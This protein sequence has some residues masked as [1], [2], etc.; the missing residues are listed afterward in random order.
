MRQSSPF[1]AVFRGLVN[2]F[3]FF[4]TLQVFNLRKAGA[5]CN[6]NL[7]WKTHITTVCAKA[8]KVICIICKARQ[9]LA[10]NTLSTL[11]NSLLLPY[12]NYCNLIWACTHVSHLEPLLLLQ[13]KAVRIITF[14]SPRSHTKPLFSKLNTLPMNAIFKFQ[15]SCFVFSHITNLLPLSLSSLFQF[16]F[17]YHDHLTRSRFNLHREFLKY[18]FAIRS[19]APEIWNSLPRSFRESLTI[20]N[21]RKKLKYFFL[22][23]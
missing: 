5:Y 4:E 19:Q 14:S 12:L 2:R 1:A 11:Y 23:E 21:F 10:S 20:H 22:H 6:E 16:N 9:Y 13:K 3:S 17:A 8:S 18:H 7:S 15:I